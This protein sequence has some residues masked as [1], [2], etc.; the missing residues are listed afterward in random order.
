[1]PSLAAEA[2]LDRAV[3]PSRVL[4][5]GDTFALDVLGA[6]ARGFA[7]LHIGAD[8]PPPPGDRVGRLYRMPA[9]VW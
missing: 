8:A 6:L 7:A 3:D 5:V 1:M 4:G 9:L 2:M